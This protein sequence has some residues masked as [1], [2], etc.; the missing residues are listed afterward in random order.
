MRWTYERALAALADTADLER[1][2]DAERR[3][4]PSLDRMTRLTGG[5]GEP[6][7][8]YPIVHVTGTNGK[9]STATMVPALLRGAT[10]R[11]H[12]EIARW[13]RDRADAGVVGAGVVGWD[14]CGD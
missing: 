14:G 6:Q 9:T 5:L 10:G 12:R 3:P 2:R 8:R 4:P 11:D 1:D 7:R 13:I